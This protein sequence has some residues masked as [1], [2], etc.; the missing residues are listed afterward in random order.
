[1]IMRKEV[2]DR[3]HESVSKKATRLGTVTIGIYAPF[4]IDSACEVTLTFENNN[5]FTQVMADVQKVPG[6]QL[7]GCALRE[8]TFWTADQERLGKALEQVSK[9]Y[10]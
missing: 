10:E 3:G 1:M 8:A 7:I 2:T 6:V 4:K 9:I 5:E